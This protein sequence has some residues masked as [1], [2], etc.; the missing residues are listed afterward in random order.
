MAKQKA[1]KTLKAPQL[2]IRMTQKSKE[3]Y[4]E[5]ITALETEVNELL[6]DTKPRLYK[7]IPQNTLYEILLDLA[8]DKVDRMTLG[9]KLKFIKAKLQEK[10]PNGNL[11]LKYP[12]HH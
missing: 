9:E 3:D 10:D 5:K 6:D 7:K 4:R 2:A 1:P 12:D 8:F 11:K